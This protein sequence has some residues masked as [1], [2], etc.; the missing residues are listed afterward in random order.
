MDY[1]NYYQYRVHH[2]FRSQEL[3]ARADRERLALIATSHQRRL[4]FYYPA[5]ARFGRWLIASGLHLQKRYG[6]LCELPTSAH[7]PAHRS[8]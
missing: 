6:D 5:M 8:A 3:I 2:H 1:H 4:R 7:R